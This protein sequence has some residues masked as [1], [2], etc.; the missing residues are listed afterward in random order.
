MSVDRVEERIVGE[1]QRERADPSLV[2]FRKARKARAWVGLP[3][4]T[5]ILTGASRSQ[6]RPTLRGREE[7]FKANLLSDYFRT[8][9]PIIS[10]IIRRSVPTGGPD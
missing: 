1:A 7:K 5:A 2:L 10:Y 8:N 4:A 9:G 6:R 3:D